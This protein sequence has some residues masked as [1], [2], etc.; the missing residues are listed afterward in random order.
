MR[1]FIAEL[2]PEF[3]KLENEIKYIMESRRYSTKTTE[4]LV[5]SAFRHQYPL[6]E[7][8]YTVDNLGLEV[9]IRNSQRYY[10]KQDYILNSLTINVSQKNQQRIKK[11]QYKNKQQSI[12]FSFDNNNENGM[13]QFALKYG[14]G[15]MN[16]SFTVLLKD[17]FFEKSLKQPPINY[18]ETIAFIAEV[19]YKNEVFAILKDFFKVK[20]LSKEQ[21]D[22]IS[23]EHDLNLNNHHGFVNLSG[24]LLSVEESFNYVEDNK[25]DLVNITKSLKSFQ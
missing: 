11:I 8:N 3:E 14:P 23:L 24:K 15:G 21:K 17:G 19:K 10:N 2:V 13:I 1:K 5:Y 18:G 6:F 20:F 4:E 12:T 9:V 7:K 25:L 16:V 22:L